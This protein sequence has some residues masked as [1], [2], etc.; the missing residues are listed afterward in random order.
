MSPAVCALRLVWVPDQ[1]PPGRSARAFA[2]R[3]A[4]TTSWSWRS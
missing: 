2:S 3:T 4:I 1:G